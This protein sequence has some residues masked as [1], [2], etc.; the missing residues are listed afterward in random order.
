MRPKQLVDQASI[1]KQRRLERVVNPVSPTKK[2]PPRVPFLF[3]AS[4]EHGKPRVL[5][6]EVGNR[7]DTDWADQICP[8]PD[9]LESKNQVH[10]QAGTAYGQFPEP[11]EG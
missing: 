8:I 4:H 9:A 7:V 11:G 10:E 2:V 6:K 5:N 3:T 1:R